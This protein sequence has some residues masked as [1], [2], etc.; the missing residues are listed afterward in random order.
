MVRSTITA[1]M[2]FVTLAIGTDRSS[3]EAPRS[4]TPWTNTAD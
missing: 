1:V 4:P 3:A 2:T